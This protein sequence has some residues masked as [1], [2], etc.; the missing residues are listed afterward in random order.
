MLTLGGF[1]LAFTFPVAG[2]RF[3]SRRAPMIHDTNAIGTAFLRA[4]QIPEPHS[5]NSCALFADYVA[6]R[7]LLFE[8]EPQRSFRGFGRAATVWFPADCGLSPA[9]SR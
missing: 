3:A 2:S 4:D 8:G 7:L 5:F 6:R 9:R 1:L